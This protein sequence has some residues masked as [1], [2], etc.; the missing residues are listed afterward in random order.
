MNIDTSSY[1]PKSPL[2]EEYERGNRDFFPDTSQPEPSDNK[3]LTHQAGSGITGDKEEPEKDPRILTLIATFISWVLV[4][5]FMPVYGV[6]LIFNL[7]IFQFTPLAAKWLLTGI[8]FGFNVIVPMILILLLK[9]MGMVTDIGLNK[10]EERPIPYIITFVCMGGTAAFFGYKGAPLWVAMFFAG[11]ALAS[12]INL[13]INTKWKVSAHSAGIAGIVALL[14]RIL[15]QEYH[16]PKT[17]VWLIVWVLLAGLLGST[18]VWQRRHTLAQ[19]LAGYAIG[20]STVYF[21]TMI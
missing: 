12:V 13:I 6:L 7:S 15:T 9:R 21:L 3:A 10:R 2:D 11:G 20:F 4:P 14:V 19:V 16:S 17:M 8:V 1:Y 5:L 18:R